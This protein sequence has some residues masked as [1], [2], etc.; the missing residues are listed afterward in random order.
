MFSHRR[1]KPW[2]A[3]ARGIA[4]HGRMVAL[5]PKAVAN[6]EVMQATVAVKRA[7]ASGPEAA[8]RLCQ[9]IA[10]RLVHTTKYDAVRWVELVAEQHDPVAYFSQATPSK[11][12]ATHV[13]ARCKVPVL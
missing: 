8:H 13:H 1:S 4:S 12:L 5:D 9:S 3:R 6:D 2:L 10:S 7:I 11:P